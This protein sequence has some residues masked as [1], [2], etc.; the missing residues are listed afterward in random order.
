[1]S[2]D[3]VERLRECARDAEKEAWGRPD[4]G[5]ELTIDAMLATNAADL[6]EKHEAE[7]TRLRAELARQGAEDVAAALIALA[8][9]AEL[10]GEKLHVVQPF[11]DVYKKHGAT[12]ESVMRARSP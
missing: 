2:G 7:I 12:I 6:I 5:Q 10:V 8:D 3:V 9:A 11:F 1:M 4:G